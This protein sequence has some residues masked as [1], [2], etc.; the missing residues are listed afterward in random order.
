MASHHG[1][2]GGEGSVV[3]GIS[4]SRVDSIGDNDAAKLARMEHRR[5]FTERSLARWKK[6][7]TKDVGR[8]IHPDLKSWEELTAT[9]RQYDVDAAKLIPQLLALD[10]KVIYGSKKG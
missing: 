6:G 7:D 10:K 9:V 4:G 1:Q 2:A 3:S 8:R 5:W